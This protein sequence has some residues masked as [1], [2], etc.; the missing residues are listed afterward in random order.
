M[1]ISP[2]TNSVEALGIPV[3][4][5]GPGQHARLAQRAAPGRHQPVAPGETRRWRSV[6][7]SR[8]GCARSTRRPS[9]TS[10]RATTSRRPW[11]YPSGVSHRR[12]RLLSKKTSCPQL[13]QVNTRAWMEI[14]SGA[15]APG[16]WQ[17]IDATRPTAA[18]TLLPPRLLRTPVRLCCTSMA[19]WQQSLFDQGEAVT[20][21]PVP[22]GR[23][24]TVLAGGAWL[25]S[26]PGG[27]DA[28]TS[29]STTSPRPFPGGSRSGRCTTGRCSSSP[30]GRFLPGRRVPPSPLPLRG[31]GAPQPAV[32]QR[33]RWGAAQH[34]PVP[35]PS[36]GATAWPGTA[37]ASG[38]TPWPTR[39][40]PSSRSADAGRFSSVRRPAGRLCATIS[41]VVTS[42]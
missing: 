19:L 38:A 26:T 28:R 15:V 12:H 18:L 20:I 10:V 9:A 35:L 23:A 29:C 17:V 2:C 39:S 14:R 11:T 8:S 24:R 5:A 41:G 22:P 21:G 25:E 7:M 40:W 37:T 1:A 4:R 32:R 27:S 42:W 36:T 6:A 16:R 13:S 33:Y 31:S 3:G 34:R 30:A